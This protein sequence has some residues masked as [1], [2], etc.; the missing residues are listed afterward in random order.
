MPTHEVEQFLRGIFQRLIAD[1]SLIDG[2]WG[3]ENGFMEV[4][5]HDAP[6]LE[7]I[8][9][10][11]ADAVKPHHGLNEWQFKSIVA[12]L[13]NPRWTAMEEG[14]YHADA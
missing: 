4:L 12:S 8:A 6:I 11:L 3:P 7:T 9:G 13:R 14:P 5:A 2:E 1:E 10:L